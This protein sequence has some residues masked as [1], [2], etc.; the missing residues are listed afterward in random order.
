MNTR[1][2]WALGLACIL[3]VCT[4]SMSSAAEPP[5]GSA[6]Q[7]IFNP[8]RAPANKT[9]GLTQRSF[10]ELVENSQ[11]RLEIALVVDGTESMGASLEGIRGAI[12]DMIQDL[13][14]FKGEQ[15]AFQLIVF[16]DS[17]SE[18]G[19]VSFPL[20][21]VGK[22]FT[23]D[24]ALLERAFETMTADTGA[25]YFPELIDKGIQAALSEL[26]WSTDDQTSRWLIVFGDAPP[27][28]AGFD[29]PDKQ[30]SRRYDTSYL[31]SLA[32]RKGIQIN[33]ILCTSRDEEQRAYESVLEKTRRFMSTLSSETGGLMLD[34]SYPDIRKALEEAAQK[35]RVSYSKVGQI[36]Q[37]DLVQL[38]DI[39]VRSKSVLAEDRR[40]RLAVLP[41]LPL[42]EMSFDPRKKEVI[43]ATDLREKLRRIP[44]VEV[45]SPTV[46]S[47]QLPVLL[48]RGIQD[49][50]LIQALAT[51]LR[52]DYVLWGE[53]RDDNGVEKYVSA[54]YD[55]T[56]GTKI[57]EGSAIGNV[58]APIGDTTSQITRGLITNVLK[59]RNDA[60][61]TGAFVALNSVPGG[62]THGTHTGFR[63]SRG[64]GQSAGRLRVLGTGIG[65]H[66]GRCRGGTPVASRRNRAVPVHCRGPRQCLCSPAARQLSVRP[67]TGVVGTE[68]K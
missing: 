33:C 66:R 29:E 26:E 5:A 8:Q 39:A 44:G 49:D 6:L 57:A 7:S 34:L 32:E 13:E 60:K 41:H 22:K 55:G 3:L 53:V 63:C 25:P 18:A 50:Q 27:Y 52:V 64:P 38:R 30:A 43:V 61:L 40:V 42:H 58:D 59:T 36:T 46:I 16:R 51:V 62:G 11:P 20:T 67:G 37:E 17:G 19:E 45:K 35:P 12:R 48:R 1:P 2:R 23:S 10:I 15:L 31:V 9:M 28:D 68:S 54:I 65:V 47:R 24:H 4:A 21:S 14:L 56:N